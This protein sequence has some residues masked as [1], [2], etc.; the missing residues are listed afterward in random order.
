[1]NPILSNPIQRSLFSQSFLSWMED[2]LPFHS[3]LFQFSLFH[4]SLFHSIPSHPIDPLDTMEEAILFHSINAVDRDGDG[5]LKDQEEAED[6]SITS[7]YRWKEI[8]P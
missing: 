1:M 7:K 3:S 8:Q 4:S 2:A 5:E 6:H